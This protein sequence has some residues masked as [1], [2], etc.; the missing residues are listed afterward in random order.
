[1]DRHWQAVHTYAALCTTSACDAGILT[2]VAFMRKFGSANR[3][4]GPVYAWRPALLQ[5]V[6]RIALEWGATGRAMSTHPGLRTGGRDP[7]LAPGA[8]TPADR[9]LLARSYHQLP[10][11]A[12][13]LLWHTQV[14]GE[15]I[16]GP[17]A[18]V[19]LDAES[20]RHERDRA[21]LALRAS[22]VRAHLTLATEEQCRRYNRLIEAVT[23]ASHPVHLPDLRRHTRQCAHC[24]HALDQLHDWPQRLPLLL[25][26]S[27]LGWRADEY[28]SARGAG[29]STGTAERSETRRSFT[30]GPTGRRRD[31][32]PGS[33]SVLLSVAMVVLLAVAGSTVAVYLTSAT[34][35]RAGK[36]D[37]G[38]LPAGSTPPG[39]GE[40]GADRRRQ[41]PLPPTAGPS[42]PAAH[43]TAVRGSGTT[44]PPAAAEE[45]FGGVTVPGRAVRGERNDSP[46]GPGNCAA[47]G[48]SR[49]AGDQDAAGDRCDRRPKGRA[50]RGRED[51]RPERSQDGDR[52]AQRAEQARSRHQDEPRGRDGTRD[53]GRKPSR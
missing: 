37:R 38:G 3:R 22:C 26:E 50:G 31:P 12:Q 45:A 6:K 11:P 17:A 39:P 44:A 7:L 47:G 1:M 29:T 33:R 48:R 34:A 52:P 35:I 28:L 15:E 51:D 36:P 5:S 20:A 23:R 30:G 27:V 49:Q 42:A 32:R 46:P 43:A 16:S 21:L 25:A 41:E 8:R 53:H 40:A 10:E 14:E 24:R 13:C 18:L 2:G 4:S 9:R 19:G